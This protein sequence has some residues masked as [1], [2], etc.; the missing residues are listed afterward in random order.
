MTHPKTGDGKW[1][2][3]GTSGTIVSVEGYTLAYTDMPMSRE[4]LNDGG[5]GLPEHEGAPLRYWV[6]MSAAGMHIL[7]PVL[8]VIEGGSA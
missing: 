5:A 6:R 3:V 1:P 7:G 8:D 4:I 2:K